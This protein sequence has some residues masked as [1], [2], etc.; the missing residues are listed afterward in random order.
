MLVLPLAVGLVGLVGCGPAAGPG[1]GT[2][3]AADRGPSPTTEPSDSGPSLTTNAQDG[4]AASAVLRVTATRGRLSEVTVSSAYGELAGQLNGSG[5][6]WTSSQERAPKVT[7]Q[8]R[9]TATNDAGGTTT[10]DRSF[11]TGASPRTLT[12]DVTPWGDQQVGVGQPIVVKLSSSVTGT[13][14]RAEV[15][16]GLVVRADREI[17][18][19]SWSWL[20]GTELHYR[21]QSFWPAN[22]KVQVDVKFA[23]VHAGRGLW[24]V[25]DRTV[26]FRIGRAFVMRIND[27]THRMTVTVDGKVVRT[28]PVSMGRTGYE[29]RSG[30]KTIMSHEKTVR[31]T[32]ASYGGKDYY[33]EIVH[34]GQRLTWSGEFI[35]SAPWSVASQ[36]VRNVSHGCVNI[37]PTDAVWLFGQTLIGDPV[38]TTG[39]KRQMEPGN[40]TGGD[41][42][43]AWATWTGNSALSGPPQ[44]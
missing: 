22:T 10:L 24:G 38:I 5:T 33:D 11:T 8:V 35:H 42:N 13:K 12:A 23:G 27:A 9:A 1:S 7:Y 34:Y 26:S 20:S 2:A 16:K 36:G 19:A 18:P 40:G 32:S 41:W 4:L 14:A 6:E 37:S 17:G 30:I 29:T 43:V 28:I 44:N 15:E 31:M 3:S 39:T 21:P 25:K